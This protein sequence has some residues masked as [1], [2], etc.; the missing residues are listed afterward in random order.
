[1]SSL[2]KH[3]YWFLFP[4]GLI[5]LLDEW[6]KYLG[7]QNLPSESDIVN[8]DIVTF[9]IHKNWGAAFNFPFR[10][11]FIILFSI[12]IG[13]GLLHVALK[14]FQIQ[15]RVTFASLVIVLGALGNLYDRIVYGFTV[16]YIIL[17]A[18][19]AINLSDIVIIS[20]VVMLLLFSRN[21]KSLH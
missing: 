8:P 17:F 6:L 14:N 19:S 18:R 11:E 21:K 4:I 1:M 10:L 3:I 15:P 12:V 13:I 16:D 20:G 2:S 7:L 9:A 5:V